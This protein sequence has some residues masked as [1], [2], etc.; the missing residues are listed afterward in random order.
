MMIILTVTLQIRYIAFTIRQQWRE[1]SF[2]TE[3][4]QGLNVR[5]PRFSI[6]SFELKDIALL[7]LHMLVNSLI[8]YKGQCTNIFL[9]KM[10]FLA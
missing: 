5:Y 1:F 8:D 4:K 10:L 7:V 2:I 9:D 6:K 3:S